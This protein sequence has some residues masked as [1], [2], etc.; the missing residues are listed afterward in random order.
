VHGGGW[1]NGS[2]LTRAVDMRHFADRGWLAVS[3]EY[4]LS[5]PGL[6]TWDIAGPDVAC[7]LTQVVAG[8]A[9]VGGDP[10]RIVL[11]GDSAGGQLAVAVGYHAAA[12]DQPSSCGGRV[13]VPRAVATNYPAVDVAATYGRGSHNGSRTTDASALAI[14]YLGGTPRQFPDRYRAVS[15]AA[16][17]TRAAPPTLVLSPTRDALVPPSS[18]ARF[19]RSARDGG[20]DATLVS[21]PFANHAYDAYGDGSLGQQVG[22]SL[23]ENWARAHV[24]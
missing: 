23:I 21:I 18:L 6:P 2:D 5:R 7:A 12:S 16:A 8:A 4:T 10:S 24:T 20:V 19:V 3:V 15:G 22:F 9:A 11:A 17:I 14:G 13:P 1:A